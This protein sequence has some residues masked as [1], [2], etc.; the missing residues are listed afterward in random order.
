MAIVE[1]IKMD[2]EKRIIQLEAEYSK[3]NKPIM[4]NFKNEIEIKGER[5][6]HSIHP[7]PAKLIPHIPLFFLHNNYYSES[8]DTVLDPFVGAGTVS[9][10]ASINSRKSI[11]I[12]INPL[13]CLISTVK[14]TYIENELLKNEPSELI[15]NYDVKEF[16]EPDVLNLNFWFNRDISERLMIIKTNIENIKNLK[17]QNFYKICFSSMLKKVSNAD[18]RIAVPVKS[19]KISLT[20]ELIDTLF[21]NSLEQNIRRNNRLEENSIVPPKIINGNSLV[22]MKKMKKDSIKMIITSPPYPGAQKYIRSSFLNLGWLDLCSSKG[23]KALKYGTIGREEVSLKDCKEI[24]KF[25][26]YE[27]DKILEIIFNT[28]KSRYGVVVSYLQEMQEII[29]ESYRVLQKGGHFIMI[30]GNGCICKQNFQ[31]QKYLT[32]IANN[33]GLKMKFSLIDDIKSYGLMTK[34]NKTANIISCEYVNV[35]IKE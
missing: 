30:V 5:L 3:Y 23:L 17:L 21:L 19:K 27:L 13:A 32:D 26:N 16:Y 24:I 34:R 22:E 7:Y 4:F 31:T 15:L 2:F 1:Q 35:F 29:K 25:E 8:G 10:E 12:D 14:S 9:L 18:P 28:N 6:T 11:G 33:I 20:A